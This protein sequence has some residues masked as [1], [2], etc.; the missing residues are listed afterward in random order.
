MP[1]FVI[2][3]D[4]RRPALTA[5]LTQDGAAIDLTSA[6]G[7][8]LRAIKS[9]GTTGFSGSCTVT[10]ASSGA[11]SYAFAAGDTASPGDYRL[12]FVIDWGSSIYQTVPTSQTSLLRVTPSFTVD[13]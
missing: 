13:T 3:Q 1:A 9:D 6:S 8:E 12:A 2:G 5:T 4:D 11:V 10:G 7:V